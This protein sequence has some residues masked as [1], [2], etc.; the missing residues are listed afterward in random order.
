MDDERNMFAGLRWEKEFNSLGDP[1]IFFNSSPKL[2]FAAR[3]RS[4]DDYELT[5]FSQSTQAWRWR[6]QEEQK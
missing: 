6:V 5:L 3:N 2:E 4:S 1:H